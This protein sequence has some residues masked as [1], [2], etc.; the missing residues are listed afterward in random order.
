M[1]PYKGR[2][3]NINLLVVGSSEVRMF[4][5]GRELLKREYGMDVKV[6]YR[7]GC[8][9]DYCLG[10]VQRQMKPTTHLIIVWAL[11]PYGWRRTGIRTRGKPE[12]T[13][14]RPAIYFSL[15][16]IP[17][18]MNQI[19]EYVYRVNPKCLV[20]L[21]IPAVKD[22]YTFNQ[23]RIVR[24]WGED[25]QDF[26]KNHTDYNPK[27]MRKHSVYVY[28]QFT[29]LYQDTYYWEGKH[30]IYGNS[31]LNCYVCYVKKRPD[32]AH[33]KRRGVEHVN[34]LNGVTN[35]LNSDLLPDGLHGNQL[36]FKYYWKRNKSILNYVREINDIP[37][38]FKPP[39]APPRPPLLGDAPTITYQTTDA[40]GQMIHTSSTS[41]NLENT[42]R[43]DRVSQI[44]YTF[45]D[46]NQPST[47]RDGFTSQGSFQTPT[48][49]EYI[50][51]P[52]T[53]PQCITHMPSSFSHQGC[54][55]NPITNPLV[56]SSAFTSYDSDDADVDAD[57]SV[58]D[59]INERKRKGHSDTEVLIRDLDKMIKT[60]KKE[61]EILKRRKYK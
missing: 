9:L 41:Q 24:A 6:E 40:T 47:S 31:A 37:P 4:V 21:A 44:L 45:T 7:K 54:M 1:D 8:T 57:I 35:I 20:Y 42:E 22:L 53:Q 52:Y 23:T 58:R 12:I 17:R 14:F 11:T 16:D 25:Y 28:D 48:R 10:Q 3:R 19:V 51:S 50:A 32:A 5:E 46:L 38:P 33:H 39:V 27:Q 15:R 34:F 30:L 49:E 61:Q 36:F 26:L 13:I 29:S 60:V 18:L 43:P 2:S 56:Y 55:S 59:F